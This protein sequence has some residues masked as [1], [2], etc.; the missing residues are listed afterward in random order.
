MLIKSFLGRITRT[1]YHLKWYAWCS[2]VK[3][4]LIFKYNALRH[5]QRLG[6]C[7]R[8]YS[9]FPKLV[10]IILIVST[11]TQKSFLDSLQM[12]FNRGDGATLHR[13]ARQKD[14]R[15]QSQVTTRNNPT[16]KNAL[17]YSIS[18][19]KYWNWAQESGG[20]PFL[21]IFVSWLKQGP[22]HPEPTPCLEQGS[23]LE[24]SRGASSSALLPLCSYFRT[25]CT[26]SLEESPAKLWEQRA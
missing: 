12:S 26:A 23:G 5:G 19:I 2:L 16:V 10:S 22:E 17:T 1:F 15:H 4:F 14:L 24:T 7:K 6:W 25:P 20:S 9:Y 21:D 13:H 11:Q 8:Y 3:V 18:T